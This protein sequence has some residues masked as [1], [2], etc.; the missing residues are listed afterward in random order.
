[1]LQ[2]VVPESSAF[3]LRCC[4]PL[5]AA[6]PAQPPP[7]PKRGAGGGGGGAVSSSSDPRID[8]ADRTAQTS[9]ADL[10]VLVLVLG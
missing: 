4:H 6:W 5:Q 1:M 10:V 3:F 9:A 8:A 7:L 2:S